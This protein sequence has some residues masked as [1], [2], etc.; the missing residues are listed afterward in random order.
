MSTEEAFEIL[1]RDKAQRMSKASGWKEQAEN[2]G[3]K[4]DEQLRAFK[5]GGWD[6]MIFDMAHV[7]DIH[8]LD[9]EFRKRLVEK[10]L[11]QGL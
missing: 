11:R 10:W 7:L 6:E 4:G 8:F 5:I 3:V 9:R 1:V 2:L